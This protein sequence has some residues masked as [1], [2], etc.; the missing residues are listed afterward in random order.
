MIERDFNRPID[1]RVHALGLALM[2]SWTWLL[3]YT[4]PEIGLSRDE[5]IYV[6]A[7]DSYARWFELLFEQ[8]G[9]ALQRDVIDRHWTV[10]HEHP[11]LPKSLFALSVLVQKHTG[12]FPIDSLVYRFPAMLGAGALLWLILVFGTRLHGLGVGLFAALG[13]ALLPRVFYHSHL[14]AFDVPITLAVA[15]TIYAYLRSLGSA[16]WAP[17]AGLCFGL[18][19]ATKHNSWLLPPS[20]AL[21]FALAAFVE[22]RRR[23][24]GAAPALSRVPLGLICMLL[25]GPP[26]LLGSWPWL[27]HDTLHRLDAYAAFHL[28]HEYYNMAYFGVNYFWPPFPISYPW[29]MTLFTVPLTTLALAALGVWGALGGLWRRLRAG[30]VGEAER[31]DPA[32]R[33]VLLLG[34]MLGPPLLIALPSTPIF[35]GT[36]HWFTAYPMLAL[37]AG[38]GFARALERARAALAGLRGPRGAACAAAA[39]GVLLLP[40][41]LETAHSHP[42]GLSHYGVA[43]GGVPGAADHGMNRQFWGF[44]TG[45]LDAFFKQHLP[46]GGSIYLCDSLPTTL[47]M[48]VRDGRLPKGLRASPD[49]ALADYALVHHEHHFAEVDHQIWAAYGSVQPA[50]VLT[51]DGVPIVSVYENPRRRR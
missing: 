4:S 18:A 21:H 15:G 16:R 8:P 48:L 25:L 10:N 35:G 24:A 11:S 47:S 36:K 14:D 23:R 46:H 41:A 50:Y 30:F 20:F 28:K 51:Y 1:R 40:A 33:D 26:L 37:Y 9:R 2:L 45:S 3:H 39:A 22:T 44:T 27:W 29:L 12:L 13:F 34:C 38:L 49:I 5:A 43:A 6:G 31:L 42:F 7:A 19:L 17:V 32:L